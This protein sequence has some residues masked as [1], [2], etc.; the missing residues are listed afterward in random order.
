MIVT[1]T[2]GGA[3]SKLWIQIKA[4]NLKTVFYIPECRETACLGAALIGAA[5]L[6]T[7]VDWDEFVNSWVR[8]KKSLRPV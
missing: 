2:G 3:K 8:Y 6:K 7:K 5:G 1:A 4:N